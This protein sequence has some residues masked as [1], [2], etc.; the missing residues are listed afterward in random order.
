MT[1]Q[2]VTTVNQSEAISTP[3]DETKL[4]KEI[5]IDRI[6]CPLHVLELKQGLK[7]I[8]EG[9]V[10]KVNTTDYVMPELLAAARQIASVAY[11][12]EGDVL[13]VIK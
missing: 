6:A 13:F 2:A 7:A 3:I 4:A 10:L 1:H 5:T 8:A 11:S 12:A 9:A